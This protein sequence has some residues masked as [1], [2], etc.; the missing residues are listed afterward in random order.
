MV[1]LDPIQDLNLKPILLAHNKLPVLEAYNI[2]R[3]YD[4]ICIAESYLDSTVAL[5]D[6]TLSK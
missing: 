4:I 1:I 2:T 6:N 3:K 5:D